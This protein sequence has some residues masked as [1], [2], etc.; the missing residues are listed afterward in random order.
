MSRW[1]NAGPIA[2]MEYLSTSAQWFDL[3]CLFLSETLVDISSRLPRSPKEHMVVH[4]LTPCHATPYHSH[5]HVQQ[6]STCSNADT[7]VEMWFADCS[8]AGRQ[9]IEGN[10]WFVIDI[11]C[12]I[13]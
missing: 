8:P 12:F 13:V 5:L 9:R 2:A 6:S 10:W 1:H 3:F 7:A 11:F 4:F